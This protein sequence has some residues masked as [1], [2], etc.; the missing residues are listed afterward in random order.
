LQYQYRDRRNSK[1]DLRTLW[2]Q[3]INA[4][5]RLHGL[6]YS[7]FMGLAAQANVR[8]DRKILADLAVSNQAAF[9]SVVEAVRK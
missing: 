7:R 5:L 2:I 1:R 9:Q 3:R 8:L 4:A 6:S